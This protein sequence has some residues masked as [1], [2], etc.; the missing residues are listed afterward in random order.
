MPAGRPSSYDPAVCERAI[1]ILSE[2][3]SMAGLAGKL[4]VAVQ[5]VYN[6]ADANP[7]FM[8]AVKTGQAAAA[9]WWEDRNRA[10][11]MGEPGNATSVI[12]GL[13]N[14]ARQEWADISRTE[15]T[16]ADGGPIKAEVSPLDRMAAL[17]DAKH[18]RQTGDDPE[19]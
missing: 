15:H 10:I 5:T 17:L 18:S 8:E 4:G 12:F 6:W 11:A 13:K 14:R 2:G 7:E 9:A 3:Y 16:G 1:E 19:G